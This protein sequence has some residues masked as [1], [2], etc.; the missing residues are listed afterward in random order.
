MRKRLAMLITFSLTLLLVITVGLLYIGKNVQ[1]SA[2]NLQHFPHPSTSKATEAAQVVDSEVQLPAEKEIIKQTWYKD[3]VIVLT[4]HHIDEQSKQPLAITPKQFSEHMAYLY[5]HDFHPITLSEFLRFV[6]TG[7]M[8]T[9]N[10]VL[11]TFDDGYESFYSQAFPV[12]KEYNFPSVNF[13]ITGR[14]RDT[15]ERKREN[16]TPPLTFTEIEE[17]RRS[18]LVEVASHTY[19]LH[20]QAVQNEWG[21]PGPDT[22][23]VYMEDLKRVENEKEYRDRLYVDFM[24]SRVALSD[25][26]HQQIDTISFPFGYATETIVEIAK[27]AG[28][29]YAFSTEHGV[30][31]E[32]TDPYRIPRYDV[33]QREMDVTRLA[34]LFTSVRTNKEDAHVQSN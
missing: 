21:E 27:Q 1:Q 14:L 9:E 20:E 19:S 12:L 17:M 6:D 34:E 11:I 24:M 30:V 29:K 4:Y 26:V 10:A 31:R 33:G 23:P 22:A 5:E 15:T 32:G 18:G 2:N 13:V 25:L 16:M 7:S 3:Q 8:P 28:F